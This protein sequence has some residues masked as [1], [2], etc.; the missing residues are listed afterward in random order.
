MEDKVTNFTESSVVIN[1]YDQISAT[2]LTAVKE[3]FDT[4]DLN[5]DYILNTSL[6]VE[7]DMIETNK[8]N[9]DEV[10][11]DDSNNDSEIP[12]SHEQSPKRQIVQNDETEGMPMCILYRYIHILFLC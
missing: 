4:S 2:D 6:N 8:Q 10:A 7:D 3:D 5:E 9:I 12:E 11:H 1:E